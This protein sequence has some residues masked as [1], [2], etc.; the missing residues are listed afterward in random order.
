[1]AHPPVV[2][3]AVAKLA[4]SDIA[5]VNV[6]TIP[7]ALERAESDK[8][9]FETLNERQVVIAL[10]ERISMPDSMRELSVFLNVN[11]VLTP[12]TLATSNITDNHAQQYMTWIAGF[13]NDPE[14]NIQK[15]SR[16]LLR[17]LVTNRQPAIQKKQPSLDMLRRVADD[18]ESTWKNAA[19]VAYALGICGSM[20]DYERVIRQSELVIA[21][22][23]E[24]IELVAEALYR[25]YPPALINALQYFI[26]NTP[27]NSKEFIAGLQLLAKVSEIEDQKFWTTYFDDMAKMVD[28]V[29]EL[30]G[31]NSAVERI[32]DQIEKH[33]A[34]VGSDED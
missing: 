8:I 22:D 19:Y 21:H 2:H 1:M 7:I 31:R 26:E 10:L 23:R 34:L 29:N 18:P 12:A 14:P 11:H 5:G 4:R 28:K 6:H 9:N 13:L 20:E 24:G 33:L 3:S 27:P 17:W 25:M 16:V 30:A 32:L 15:N